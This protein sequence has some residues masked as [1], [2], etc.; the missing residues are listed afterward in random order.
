MTANV[1]IR[2]I[3]DASGD[4]VDLEY[5]HHSCSPSDVLGWPAPESLDYPVYCE[6][7]GDRVAVGLT[8]D[9]LAEMAEHPAILTDGEMARAAELGYVLAHVVGSITCY[10]DDMAIHTPSI[11]YPAP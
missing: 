5:F 4:L 8:D 11:T 1:H 9:G 10:C 3:E 6:A 7:C 2:S